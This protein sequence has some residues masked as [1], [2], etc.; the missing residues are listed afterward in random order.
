VLPGGFNITCNGASDG[1]IS[2]AA[3]GGDTSSYSFTWS[4]GASTQNIAAL[5]AGTYTLNVT[6]ANACSAS[7]SATLNEPNALAANISSP[8]FN[9]FNIDCNGNNSGSTLLIPSGGTQPYAYAWSNGATTKDLNAIQAGNYAVTITDNANCS[10]NTSVT[11]N[12]PNPLALS[13]IVPTFAGGYNVTCN[14]QADASI[15]LIPSGGTQTY[16]YN[17]SNGAT[18]QDIGNLSA[19]SFDVTVT[20]ANGCSAQKNIPITEPN[21]LTATLSPSSYAGGFNAGC[22]GFSNASI[23]LNTNG[24]VSA[25]TYSWSNG[26]ISKD[27][28]N[29]TAGKYSVTVTDANLCQTS[30]SIQ[31]TQPAMLSVSVTSAANISC[32]AGNN[33]SIAINVS[34]GDTNSYAF[35]WSNGNSTQNIANLT[36]GFYAITV[37]DANGCSANT[38]TSLSEPSPLL[39][40]LSSPTVAGGYNVTCNGNNDGAVSANLNGGNAISYAFAWSNGASTQNIANL[41]AGTYAL[42]VTDASSCTVIDSITLT[43]PQTVAASFSTSAFAGGYQIS[44]NGNADGSIDVTPSGGAAPYAF[45]W[46]NNATT[47]DLSAIQAGNYAITITDLNN[48]NTSISVTLTEPAALTTSATISNFNG[49]AVSCHGAADASILIN[50]SGGTAPYSFNWSNG[51]SL[52]GIANLNAG[53]YAVTVTDANACQTLINALLITEPL[54]ISASLSST[55]YNGTNI[56]C[57]GGSDGDIS[58]TAIGGAAPYLYSIDAGVSQQAQPLFNSLNAGNYSI[59]T[60]DANGCS[61]SQSITLSEPA[62]A[63]TAN[64]I[65]PALNTICAGDSVIL[66]AAAANSY[67]WSDGSTTQSVAIT[68][69][70]FYS[71][72]TTD[73]NGC[74]ASSSAVP[75]SVRNPAKVSITPAGIVQ[76]CQGDSVVLASSPAPSYLWS[77]GSTTN[78]ITVFNSGTYTVTVQDTSICPGTASVQ[79]SLLPAAPVPQITQNGNVLTSSTAASYQWNINGSPINGATDQ[80]YTIT[81]S[82]NYSVTVEDINGCRSTSAPLQVVFTGIQS[83]AAGFNIEASPNPFAHQL[84][85]AYSLPMDDVVEIQVVSILSQQVIAQFKGNKTSGRHLFSP[86]LTHSNAAAGMYLIRFKAGKISKTIRVVKGD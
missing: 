70:G 44:C 62:N 52:Q 27:L 65:P 66:S 50:P 74:A 42:T 84:N 47:E 36:A 40:S 72:T 64:I 21:A 57:K 78:T 33:G 51:Q 10:F 8:F 12:E 7:A 53:N 2:A 11:L 18:S 76:I 73:I 1:A 20:D 56:S 37:T 15:D 49:F 43:A 31:L 55:S 17:W 26:A 54:P 85:I 19:G 60:T 71:V 14:G 45:I 46:S 24:G 67:L 5:P 83:I 82:G 35:S 80:S 22:N 13:I 23:T 4:N 81:A 61:L 69:T 16:S 34:G 86:D 63:H 59:I 9:G 39:L 32:H 29:I 25:Y 58:V 77:E 38:S 30:D 79:V 3:S 68:S 6:D 28:T 48:C 75:V 41:T